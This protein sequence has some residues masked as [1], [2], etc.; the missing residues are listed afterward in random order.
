M[1]DRYGHPRQ[2]IFNRRHASAAASV[3]YSTSQHPPPPAAQQ[4]QQPPPLSAQTRPIAQPPNAPGR[5]LF[6]SQLTRR[7]P[8]KHGLHGGVDADGDTVVAD[9]EDQDGEGIVV[10]DLNGDFELEEPPSL[11][12]D[13]PEEIVLDMRQE[14]ESE[15]CIYGVLH[16]VRV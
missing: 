7:P 8:P 9:E 5:A 4:P 10:R 13:D 11:V 2:S 1:T 16:A 3:A 6:R 14:N 15:F 12:V